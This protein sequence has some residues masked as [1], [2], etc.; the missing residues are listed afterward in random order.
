MKNILFF[1]D[2]L[3]AGYGLR[4]AAAESI[5]ALIAQRITSAKLDYEVINAGVSGDTS[6]GG[7]GR[8]DYWLHRPVSVFVLELGINDVIRGTQPQIILKNL[9]AIIDKVKTKYPD[10]KIALMGMQIPTFI[11]ASI[12]EQFSNIYKTLAAANTVAFVPFYLD[13][14]AGKTHLNL[15]DRLHPNAEGYKVIADKIWPVI[16]RLIV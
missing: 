7:L 8:L 13:G 9:Q 3:T 2:S 14:V 5:P 1:G 6:A 10:V 16:Q 15:P 4:N 11:H 12:A